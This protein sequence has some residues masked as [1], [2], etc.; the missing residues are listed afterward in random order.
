[1][2]CRNGNNCVGNV[3]TEVSLCVPLELR[4]G[5]SGVFLGGV[6][7]VIDIYAPVG[8]DVALNGADGAVN[9]GNSLVLCRLTNKDFAVLR[10]SYN[11]WG[12]TCTLRVSN[13]G[14]LATFQHGYNRVGSTKVNTYCASHIFVLLLAWVSF[15]LIVRDSN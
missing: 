11:R 8:A 2:V 12:G 1:E 13:N 7:L 5:A 4:P 3:F 10:E 14:G 15:K 9:V 6:L